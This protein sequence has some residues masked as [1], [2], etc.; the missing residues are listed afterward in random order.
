MKKLTLITLT[1][2][3]TTAL[4]LP[5]ATAQEDVTRWRLPE[6][7]K[8]RLGK[9]TINELAYSPDGAL[10]AVASNLGVW[11]YDAQTY[12]ARALLTDHTGPVGSVAFSP[13]G[14]TLASS[15]SRDGIY[16]WDVAT[17][18]VQH[19]L[20]EH[21]GDFVSVAFSPDGATLASR[22]QDEIYLWDVATWTVQ[23]TLN[24]PAGMPFSVAFSPDGATLASGGGWDGTVLLWDIAPAA[25]EIV[26]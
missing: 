5:P 20:N 16:L 3:L 8:L 23:H 21:T 18:T 7:A 13:D 1:L 11:L 4:A 6:G 12:Q 14:A 17:W 10:L 25:P 2:L 9:G 15:R 24:E 19:T 22:G 26:R